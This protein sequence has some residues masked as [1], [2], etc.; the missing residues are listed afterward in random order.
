MWCSSPFFF[1]NLWSR[2]AQLRLHGWLHADDE[3]AIRAGLKEAGAR[4]VVTA[5]DMIVTVDAAELCSPSNRS[6]LLRDLARHHVEL[7]RLLGPG[8]KKDS[9]LSSLSQESLAALY[10]QAWVAG[11]T[12]GTDALV[13]E[14]LGGPGRVTSAGEIATFVDSEVSDDGDFSMCTCATLPVLNVAEQPLM[15]K[16][17]CQGCG[18]SATRQC[19]GCLVTWY[20]GR[21]CQRV[22]WKSHKTCCERLSG[23]DRCQKPMGTGVVSS[24]YCSW[25]GHPGAALA[26]ADCKL[27]LYCGDRCAISHSSEG[28]RTDCEALRSCAI[29]DSG[30]GT[31]SEDLDMCAGLG[32][33]EEYIFDDVKGTALLRELT[34]HLG[35]EFT[36]IGGGDRFLGVGKVPKLDRKRCSKW[37][38]T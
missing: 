27:V 16:H 29:G 28:H 26:C 13:G 7:A 12:T 35:I 10:D 5:Q 22:H 24:T 6:E 18:E 37:D 21:S 38:C 14:G 19:S 9:L 11:R 17:R 3:E 23:C 20:C 33:G 25:C 36:R 1:T 34:Q 4:V 32:Y 15:G 2:L 31:G 30:D 8:S